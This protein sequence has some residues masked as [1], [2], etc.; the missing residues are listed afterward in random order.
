MEQQ[1]YQNRFQEELR[2]R[3]N[4]LKIYKFVCFVHFG[5]VSAII[6]M[7]G[8][9]WDTSCGVNVQQWLV[10]YAIL[11]VLNNMQYVIQ[12]TANSNRFMTFFLIFVNVYW[13][14]SGLEIYGSLG[15]CGK[16][17]T[18]TKIFVLYEVIINL[19]LFAL[20]VLI[21]C[22]V[23]VCMAVNHRAVYQMLYHMGDQR[24][25]LSPAEIQSLPEDHY[26]D[27]ISTHVSCSICLEDYAT[28]DVIRRLNCP[29][30]FHKNCIDNWLLLQRTCPICRANVIEAPAV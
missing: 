11:T 13:F 16:L 25:G 14:I 22:T 12:R 28:G 19:F 15:S 18:L 23:C 4:S 2:A 7:L 17:G 9:Y 30:I 5:I 29:H 8:M 10:G 6:V 1:A 26:Y 27:G 21:C 24:T 3:S 20:Y